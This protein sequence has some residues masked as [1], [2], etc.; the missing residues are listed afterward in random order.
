MLT[1]QQIA[2]EFGVAYQ[3]VMS[4]IYK[5][6]FP[7]ALKEESPRGSYYLIPRSDLNGFKPRRRGRPK[8]KDASSERSSRSAGAKKRKASEPVKAARR[9]RKPE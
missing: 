6:Y 8:P 3:T 7:G 4:W 9:R 5:G 1:T 2:V